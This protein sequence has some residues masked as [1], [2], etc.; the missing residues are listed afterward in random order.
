MR[1]GAE[2]KAVLAELDRVRLAASPT[3]TNGGKHVRINW[4][5]DGKPPRLIVVSA[6][7]S[8]WRSSRNMRAL[9]WSAPQR[10][11]R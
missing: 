9:E 11:D 6:S 7:G 2:A 8:D 1:L 3:V 10:V 4:A 5:I